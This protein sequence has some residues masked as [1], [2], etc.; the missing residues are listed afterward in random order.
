LNWKKDI[1]MRSVTAGILSLLAG[2]VFTAAASAQPIRTPLPDGS[3]FPIALAVEVPAGAST[4]YLSGIGPDPLPGA[5]QAYGDTEA[6]TRSALTKISAA[7]QGLGLSFSDVVDVHVYLAGDKAK[8]G[9][10]D[11]AGLQAAWTDFFGTKAQPD[12]PSRSTVQVAALANPG[13]L[14][15]IEVIAARPAKEH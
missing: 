6:Q 3:K 11:F 4:V 8:G 7:L 1:S 14:V 15:E 9:K 5:A 13:W 2:L 10:L 12:L